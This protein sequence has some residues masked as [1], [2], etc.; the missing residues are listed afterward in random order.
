MPTPATA[1]V[2][3]GGC[4]IEATELSEGRGTTRPFQLVGAPW[5]DPLGLAHRLAERGL[6]GVRFVPTYFRPQFQKHAGELCGGV[7][8]VVTDAASFAPY[9]TGVELLAAPPSR[10]RATSPGGGRL[11][12]SSPTG[13][14][15]ICLTG[16]DRCRQAIEAG[17]RD[18][19]DAW[20]A[21]WPADEEAFRGECAAVL[22]YS[23]DGGGGLPS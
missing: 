11:T 5:L 13:R 8:L 17:N 10:R 16:G 7:E 15:S 18:A 21:S 19:L 3:P 23:D 12:S 2:Y 1:L 22:L 4:L 9:R 6:P 20:I 14:P